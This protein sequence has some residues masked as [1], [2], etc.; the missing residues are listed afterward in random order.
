[1]EQTIESKE[2]AWKLFAISGN[3]LYY[4]LYVDLKGNL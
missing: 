2:L 3:P 4:N 1:M